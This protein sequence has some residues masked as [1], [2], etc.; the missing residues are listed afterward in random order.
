MHLSLSPLLHSWSS[1]SWGFPGS[2]GPVPWSWTNTALLGLSD[3]HHG[4]GL[5]LLKPIWW[6]PKGWVN[7]FPRPTHVTYPPTR[8]ERGPTS[9]KWFSTNPGI[10]VF[11][12]APLSRKAMHLSLLT[13]TLAIFL[14]PY[15]QL[16]GSG[17]KNGVCV[18]CFTPWASHLGAPLAW[19]PFLEGPRL[20]SLVSSPL[21]SLN[22]SLV[23][24]SSPM[25]NLW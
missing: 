15:H 22:V 1:L 10:M 23:W 6:Q 21:F 3:P 24:M 2:Q 19:S 4:P 11:I 14:I 8:S 25:G 5:S 17:F 20:P 9:R 12:C 7:A 13:L 18:W 16:K